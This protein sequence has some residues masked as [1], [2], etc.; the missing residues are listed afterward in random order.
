MEEDKWKVQRIK[1]L[2]ACT[3]KGDWI[4]EKE[5]YKE[6]K[7]TAKKAVSETNSRAYEDFYKNLDI[8]GE[9]HIFKLAKA[10]V[11]EEMG[12]RDS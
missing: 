4:S 1:E 5:I 3:K 9:K 8:K 6:A 7:R 10:N 11:P 2:M 12:H